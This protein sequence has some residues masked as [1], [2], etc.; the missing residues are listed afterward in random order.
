M[1][2]LAVYRSRAREALMVVA[3]L[4]LI[5][6]A[7]DVIWVHDVAIG[8]CGEDSSSLCL[9][10]LAGRPEVDDTNE[11]LTSRGAVSNG[12]TICGGVRSSPSVGC[13]SP[14]ARCRSFAGRHSSKCRVGAFA[15]AS[16]APCG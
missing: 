16:E 5:L 12:R 8:D 7:F 1:T 14:Q 2:Y 15:F 13:S 6:V 10:D 3:G 4:L 11:Q 9:R